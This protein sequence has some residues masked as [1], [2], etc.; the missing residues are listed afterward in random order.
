MKM[1]TTFGKRKDG[2]FYRKRGNSVIIDNKSGRRSDGTVDVIPWF[3]V[4]FP[5]HVS[6]VGQTGSYFDEWRIR[7]ESGHPWTWMDLESRRL[8]IKMGGKIPKGKAKR[9]G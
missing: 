6:Q 5:E 2:R 1:T 3:K 7:F 4:R 9:H 8:F